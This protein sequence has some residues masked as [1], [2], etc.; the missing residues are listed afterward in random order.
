MA[1]HRSRLVF[2]WLLVLAFCGPTLGDETSRPG[3][4]LL[5]N[6]EVFAGQISMVDGEFRVVLAHGELRFRSG[7]VEFAAAT[8][9]EIYA[10]KQSAVAPGDPQERLRLAQWC[11]RQGLLEE[12]AG[13]IGVARG[14]DPNN[15][16]IELMARRLELARQPP[17]AAKAPVAV[18][19]AMP[20]GASLADLDRLVRGL[21]DG[22][23][24]AFTERVQPVM[25]NNCASVACHGPQ[26]ASKLQILRVT[27][28]RPVSRRLTQRNLQNVLPWI[29]REQPSGS[30]LLK[31]A[32]TAHASGKAAPLATESV[33][34]RRLMEWVYQVAHAEDKLPSKHPE[35]RQVTRP[36]KSSARGHEVVPASAKMPAGTGKVHRDAVHA[37]WPP[38]EAS[39][40]A[41]QVVPAVG[42]SPTQPAAP[43][44][45]AQP[46][47][48]S[49]PFDPE[50][51]NRRFLKD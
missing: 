43:A 51:F 1:N 36:T 24:E 12:A 41:A 35:P 7:D 19:H 28:G 17:A 3:V 20:G 6:G 34:Y 47:G 21:P 9:R 30:D 8:V 39:A 25:M 15:P 10:R 44:A 45:Q 29:N 32:S 11:I 37:A 27:G 26:S 42:A 50:I 46:G 23:I 49:D 4:L 2:E 33:Q 38:A 48:G 14:L 18:P 22:T 31:Y 13:E 5:R 40:P 16:G